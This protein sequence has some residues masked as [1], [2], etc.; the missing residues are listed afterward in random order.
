MKALY[1]EPDEEITSVVDRLK[2]I[3]DEEVAIVVP[4]RAGLLQSI[5]NLKLLRYQAE[6]QQKRISL[7]TT[8]KTG[9]NLASAVGLTVYQKLPEGKVKGA[10]PQPTESAI[11]EPVQ[12]IPIKFRKQP[13]PDDAKS[14]ELD[15]DDISYKK[16]ADP[17]IVTRTIAVE[18]TVEATLSPEPEAG[19]ESAAPE[20][21]K[22]APQ[23]EPLPGTLPPKDS[24]DTDKP[25][26]SLSSK[27]KIPKVK[28]PKIGK[29]KLRRNARD[30]AANAKPGK[31]LGWKIAAGV[32]LALLLAGGVAAAVV[33]PKAT[34]T[35]IP[36]T[37]PVTADLPLT[38]STQAPAV[39]PDGNVVPAKT[40]EVTKDVSRQIT[41]TG[42]SEGGDKASGDITVVNTLPRNQ[43]LVARTRFQ[44]PDGR[45]Y[46]ADSG[47][48][49]PAGGKTT[50]HVTA[51][52]GGL[53]GNLA[54]G[55]RLTV[56]GL[57][58]SEAVYGQAEAA[59]AGGSDSANVNV[60]AAD[61]ERA[62]QELASQAAQEAVGEAKPKLAVGYTIDPKA[63]ATTVLSSATDPAVGTAAQ[64][65][66]I[67]GKVR[68]TYFTYQPQDLKQVL[69]PDLNSKVPAGAEL[70]DK[71]TDTF[72]VKQA[73]DNQLSGTMR[74]ETA[75][76]SNVSK[77]KIKEQIKGKKPAEA[78]A[79]LQS[80][81]QISDI[82]ISLFPF[83]VLSVP[84]SLNKIDVRFDSGSA[85]GTVPTPSP[86]ASA[87]V[88]PQL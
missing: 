58:G 49:V 76:A 72:L 14:D 53:A 83:W 16:G 46:R 57:K 74:I 34:V 50:A 30:G 65:F 73:S 23:G 68:V 63:A 44:A 21:T 48:V 17:E 41:S 20:T 29:P 69:G 59:L 22:A 18:E 12:E 54:A 82:R 78:K 15:A 66:T 39:D 1:L 11:K 10:P 4:K 31:H 3:D 38:F 86:A 7:V 2:E 75:A 81:G 55:T 60:S 24:P 5:V 25:S 9:R 13:P 32:V 27:L 71:R 45:I 40:I 87:S 70:V 47:V 61:V 52:E 33:L 80:D 84:G 42:R 88:T 85:A 8:D 35:V 6:Q 36:K 62:K 28:L 56:P 51:D 19:S 26:R 79:A 64:K 37:T 77:D 67:S 43:S